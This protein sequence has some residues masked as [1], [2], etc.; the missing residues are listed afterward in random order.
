V[1]LQAWLVTGVDEQQANRVQQHSEQA[2]DT[3]EVFLRTTVRFE[4]QHG[5]ESQALHG[6]VASVVSEAIYRQGLS[7]AEEDDGDDDGSVL[8]PGGMSAEDFSNL[9]ENLTAL[10]RGIVAPYYG[11][12]FT[13]TLSTAGEATPDEPT[14]M[15]GPGIPDTGDIYHARGN[16]DIPAVGQPADTLELDLALW[17]V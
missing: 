1:F 2:R 14:L 6:D 8:P 9:S 16:W 3:M 5:E 17:L 12:S 10:L 15:L 7:S 4:F 13:V 11:F